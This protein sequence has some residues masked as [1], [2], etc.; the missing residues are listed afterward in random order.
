MKYYQ[1]DISREALRENDAHV[2]QLGDL[3]AR[4]Q[5]SMKRRRRESRLKA[6]HIRDDDEE[7]EEEDATVVI[8]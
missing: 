3:N 7:E 5:P 2:G 8:C 1:S 4:M 6:V